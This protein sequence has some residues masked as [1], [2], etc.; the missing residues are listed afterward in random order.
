[1]RR[2]YRLALGSPVRPAQCVPR[3]VV[4]S[5]CS[6]SRL[7][8]SVVYHVQYLVLNAQPFCGHSGYGCDRTEKLHMVLVVPET[9]VPRRGSDKPPGKPLKNTLQRTSCAEFTEYISSSL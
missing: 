9:I 3:D 2:G 5:V 7:S 8:V 4:L 6:L 1:M